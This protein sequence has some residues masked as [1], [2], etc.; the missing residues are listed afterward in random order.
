M[1]SKAQQNSETGPGLVDETAIPEPLDRVVGYLLR[2][3]HTAFSAHWQ[4]TF[5]ARGLAITPVQGGMLVLIS[6]NDHLTQAALARVLNVEGPTLLQSLDRLEQQGYVRRT[7]RNNDRRSYVLR[8]TPKGREVLDL[9]LDFLLERDAILLGDLSTEEKRTLIALLKRVVL[10]SRAVVKAL[11]KAE[12]A[13]TVTRRKAP[14]RKSAQP[15]R[16]SVKAMGAE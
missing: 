8:I 5:R 1:P 13:S 14:A 12:P 9:I 10:K 2:Q 6:R 11:Q 4:L 16:T 3:A 15:R 7:R